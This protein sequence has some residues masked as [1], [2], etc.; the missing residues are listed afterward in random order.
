MYFWLIL[1]VFMQPQV[2]KRSSFL[3]ERA[4]ELKS[5]VLDLI[6][7]SATSSSYDLGL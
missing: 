5:E 6:L 4:L 1:L 2:W 3:L 7:Y